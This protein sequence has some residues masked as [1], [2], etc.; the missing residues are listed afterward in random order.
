[1]EIKK[2]TTKAQILLATPSATAALV[3]FTKMYEGMPWVEISLA[4]GSSLQALNVVLGVG[5]QL[6]MSYNYLILGGVFLL[7]MRVMKF[8][9][10]QYSNRLSALSIFLVVPWLAHMAF[11]TGFSPNNFDL[12]PF[13]SNLAAVIVVWLR[14]ESLYLEDVLPAARESIVD[15][16][17]DAVLLLNEKREILDLNPAAQ[18]LSGLTKND[19]LGKP[20]C[21]V[22]PAL[23]KEVDFDSVL[24]DHELNLDLDGEERKFDISVSTI[25]T[26]S[27]TI[28]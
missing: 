17:L 24:N 1:M 25:K 14:P 8:S 10:R 20:I 2:L 27:I 26:V 5:Y 9:P 13:I 7:L 11:I 4:P 18:R 15:G 22:W 16:M 23:C 19:V 12:S 6:I 3:I 28:L 21:D